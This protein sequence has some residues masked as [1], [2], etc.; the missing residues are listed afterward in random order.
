MGGAI[1]V[2]GRVN[3]TRHQLLQVLDVLNNKDNNKVGGASTY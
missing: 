2:L 1:H 3:E